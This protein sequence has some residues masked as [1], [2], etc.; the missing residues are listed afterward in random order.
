VRS[1]KY[2]RLVFARD[3]KSEGAHVLYLFRD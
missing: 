3:T 2:S 1:R